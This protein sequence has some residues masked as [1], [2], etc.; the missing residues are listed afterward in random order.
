MASTGIFEP[1]VPEFVDGLR[2]AV[3]PHVAR[4]ANVWQQ[5]LGRSARY[6]ERW[7][8]FREQCRQAG[9]STPTPILLNYA[10]GGFNA[11]HR[12]L[13]GD[14]YFPI[15]LAVVLSRR[16]DLAVVE[17]DAFQGGAFQFADFP[18]RKNSQTRD[19]AAG[20]GDAVLFCHPGPLSVHRRGL[21]VANRSN[22]ESAALSPAGDWSWGC[23]F[24]SIGEVGEKIHA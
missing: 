14:V 7:F 16:S 9:Q 2:A 4:I 15:Q 1:P 11:L 6:P 17:A 20:I 24:T 18:Q 23:R 12:D 22:M 10:A 13:R 8:D 19:I 5:L 3:Y 21:R